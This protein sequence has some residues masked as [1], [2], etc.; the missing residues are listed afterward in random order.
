MDSGTAS[1]RY[2][3][4]AVTENG[5][6]LPR[7][8]RRFDRVRTTYYD[9]RQNHLFVRLGGTAVPV[10]RRDVKTCFLS[11]D[12]CSI[13]GQGNICKPVISFLGTLQ[14]GLPGAVSVSERR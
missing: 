6:V 12:A 1:R 8:S 10:M 14:D 5:T 2:S 9:K 7:I 4:F 13:Q 3:R 11:E